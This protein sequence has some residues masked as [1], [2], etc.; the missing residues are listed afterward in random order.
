MSKRRDSEWLPSE[1]ERV[2]GFHL[3]V[4]DFART[5]ARARTHT[6]AHT[7]THA[8]THS[9]LRP[10]ACASIFQIQAVAVRNHVSISLRAILPFAACSDYDGTRST[11]EAAAGGLD[12]AMPGPPTRPD[13][14]GS[15]LRDA[16]NNHTIEQAVV[17]EKVTRVVYAMIASG[18]L[19]DPPDPQHRN[20]AI[21]VTSRAHQ[22]LARRL[23]A[24]STVLLKNA[25]ET[26]PLRVDATLR[27]RASGDLCVT[28]FLLF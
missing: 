14:F 16:L 17:D 28:H 19:D 4:H 10:F 6:S 18:A 21:D 9:A 23:A 26:L 22:A 25:R 13:Y 3:Q 7:P 8:H 20:A 2:Q 27:T 5:H 12:I 24:E 1:L 11:Y 15:F